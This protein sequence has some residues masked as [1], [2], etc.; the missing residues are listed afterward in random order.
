M[1]YFIRTVN[2]KHADV[3]MYTAAIFSDSII[4]LEVYPRPL[5]FREKD[6]EVWAARALWVIYGDFRGSI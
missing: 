4:P 2:P 5:V 6:A 3:P 1:I